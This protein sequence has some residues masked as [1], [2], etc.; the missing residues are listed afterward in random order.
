MKK[1]LLIALF[2]VFCSALQAQTFEGV[3][4]RYDTYKYEQN[5]DLIIEMAKKNID[6]NKEIDA[7]SKALAKSFVKTIVKNALEKMDVQ[8][9]ISSF[10]DG[11]YTNYQWIIGA[12]NKCVNFC[13]ELGRI[14]IRFPGEGKDYV[15]FPKL[16][17]G[18]A[19]EYTANTSIKDAYTQNHLVKT[20]EIKKINGMDCIP[21]YQCF[22]YEDVGGEMVDTVTYNGMLC[23][24]IP[25]DG[26]VHADYQFLAISQ[27]VSNEYYFNKCEVLS[28]LNTKV[29]A[30]N[31]SFSED[32]YKIIDSKKLFKQIKKIVDN[33]EINQIAIPYSGDAPAL[34]WDAVK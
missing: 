15:I 30:R 16:G 33:G 25:F 21:A 23:V 14:I 2:F 27:E 34:I 4:K 17:V 9:Y 24:T 19:I 6:E 10:P 5:Q 28:M 32:D 29:D 3:I 18:C 1:I 20:T 31:F 11:K 7:A 13:P 12:E 26:Y 22:K 8:K